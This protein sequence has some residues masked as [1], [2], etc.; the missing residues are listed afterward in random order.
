MARFFYQNRLV[1]KVFLH[2]IEEDFDAK[3]KEIKE[4]LSKS[5]GVNENLLTFEITQGEVHAMQEKEAC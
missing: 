4:F 1:F 5:L 3:L 2:E